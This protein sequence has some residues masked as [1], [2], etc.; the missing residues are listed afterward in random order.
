MSYG[1]S[2]EKLIFINPVSM[3]KGGKNELLSFCQ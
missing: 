2:Y 1:L 3:N